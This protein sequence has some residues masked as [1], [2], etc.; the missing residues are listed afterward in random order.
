VHLR[1]ATEG[2]VPAIRALI[3]NCAEQGLLLPRSPESIRAHLGE[4]VVAESEGEVVG[5]AALTPLS[6]ALVEVRSLVV[7]ED[8]RG[9]GIGRHI[10]LH[11][12]ER[13]HA[14][15]FP[16]VLA[17][18]KRAAPFFAALGFDEASLARFPPKVLQE[19]DECPRYRSG[20][21]IALTRPPAPLSA[22][23]GAAFSRERVLR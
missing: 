12:L 22:A 10:V 17:I 4:F 1:N 18:T 6:P 5:A 7:R 23:E 16:E 19:C 8:Q 11:L 15:G 21:K 9:R 13:A 20:K 3:D 14:Q 2:D